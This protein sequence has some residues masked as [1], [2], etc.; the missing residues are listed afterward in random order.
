MELTPAQLERFGREG[1]LFFPSLFSATEMRT[2]TDEV[3]ALYAQ[4]R[5]ERE[6]VVKVT[7]ATLT[8]VALDDMRR[9]RVVSAQQ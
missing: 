6:E 3:P 5:P 4:R 7:E 8:F 9:P 2:L 1:Y